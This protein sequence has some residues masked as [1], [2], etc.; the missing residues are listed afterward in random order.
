MDLN[1]S[2]GISL[3]E[4]VLANIF[5]IEVLTE[6]MLL[7]TFEYLDLDG[8]GEITA[9]ELYSALKK[10]EPSLAP[11]H[12]GEF[13]GNADRDWDADIDFDEFRSFFPNVKSNA[14]L[15]QE[16]VDKD[17]IVQAV[18]DEIFK[19]ILE[20]TERWKGDIAE[21]LRRATKIRQEI[22]RDDKVEKAE[23]WVKEMLTVVRRT[24]FWVRNSPSVQPPATQEAQVL[25]QE[26]AE[27]KKELASNKKNKR[28][29]A[30]AEAEENKKQAR[31]D[32]EKRGTGLVLDQENKKDEFEENVGGPLHMNS[33]FVVNRE[34]WVTQI[35]KL[36]EAAKYAS[37]THSKNRKR[38]DS[39]TT[40]EELEDFLIKIL[41]DCKVYM[42][43][44]E[45]LWE[46]SRS[47][48]SLPKL[49]FSRRGVDATEEHQ[50]DAIFDVQRYREE[51]QATLEEERLQEEAR[52]R[53][54][55]QVVL[56]DIR[57]AHK[58]FEWLQKQAAKAQET[59]RKAPEITNVLREVQAPSIVSQV[60]QAANTM[61]L[62][63]AGD[64]LFGAMLINGKEGEG[65]AKGSPH[66]S[67][68]ADSA[69]GKRRA[70]S[71]DGGSPGS[72]SDTGSP[73]P[74]STAADDVSSPAKEGSGTKEK[75]RR[76][77]GDAHAEGSPAASKDPRRGREVSVGSSGAKGGR[78]PKGGRNVSGGPSGIDVGSKDRI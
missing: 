44:Q 22:E 34:K 70:R 18:G 32:E 39:I 46:I 55:S 3:E 23:H 16:R 14:H 61:V 31:A 73:R 64:T 26:N 49:P 5:G 37:A 76:A 62:K 65:D 12:I 78:S 72:G 36:A 15:M 52:A 53:L 35:A 20:S 42:V 63:Y 60:R 21:E 67:S 57:A 56:K 45:C 2:A 38:Q 59:G 30:W 71:H 27:K 75:G 51:R 8:T 4:F 10:Y 69:K 68:P 33:F 19:A 50:D 41:D 54:K 40:L 13:M 9:M 6:R 77:N 11:A 28:A 58:G 66:G 29:L 24:M 48:Q 1:A 74:V 17:K 43:E 47:E 25:V 7:R